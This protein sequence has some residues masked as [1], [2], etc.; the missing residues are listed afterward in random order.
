[1]FLLTGW[2]FIIYEDMVDHALVEKSLKMEY[3]D[4]KYLMKGDQESGPLSIALDIGK[5][6]PV[7]VKI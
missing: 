5:E 4:F 3:H 2:T 7:S 1:M 6:G